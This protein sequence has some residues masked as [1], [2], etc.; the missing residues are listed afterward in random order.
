FG[1]FMRQ[2]GPRQDSPRLPIAGQGAVALKLTKDDLPAI[3]EAFAA[4]PLADKIYFDEDLPGFGLRLRK[5]SKREVWIC[6]YEHAGVQRKLTLGTVAVL[7]PD[8]ARE[9]ARR[10]MAEI[11]LGGDPQAKKAEER[12]KARLTLR[13]IA[14]Q[15][16]QRQESQ[17]R[18]NSL[19]D[20]KRYLLKSFRPL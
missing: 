18:S 5:G 4:S 3:R 12:A 6:R 1:Y 10:A 11:L 13:Y 20:V 16:L 9:K 19:R 7:R 14:S 2:F 15:Y 17:L 8:Q